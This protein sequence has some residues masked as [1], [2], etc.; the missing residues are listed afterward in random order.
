MHS[1]L[2]RTIGRLTVSIL[3]LLSSGA[4]IGSASGP[5]G[6]AGACGCEKKAIAEFEMKNPGGPFPAKPTVGEERT[7]EIVNVG[8]EKGT[9]AGIPEA[10][11]QNG[12]AV[13]GFF[14]VTGR[15]ACA[16]AVYAKEGGSCMFQVKI[17]KVTEP[18][19]ATVKWKATV[20]VGTGTNS[21]ELNV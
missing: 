10:E 20:T 4:L 3:L 5:L 6:T 21:Q 17:A 16:T 18:G 8:K 14:T 7:I 15:A 9:P 19:E 13:S 1:T 12:V 2:S 11:T